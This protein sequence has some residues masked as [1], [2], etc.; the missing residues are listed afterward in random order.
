MCSFCGYFV[1]CVFAG[2]M[3]W[4]VA[5]V[6]SFSTPAYVAGRLLVAWLGARFSCRILP[7]LIPPDPTAPVGPLGADLR[8]A[9]CVDTGNLLS[10][11]AS[12]LPSPPAQVSCGKR[13]ARRDD[14]RRICGACRHT[15][16]RGHAPPL[17]AAACDTP[18]LQA[19]RRTI[20]SVAAAMAAPRSTRTAS[21]FREASVR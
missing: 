3:V 17:R 20:V 16:F 5:N 11:V 8:V 4:C 2:A 13:E 14:A 7:Y 9:P 15:L 1:A 21:A 6:R 19:A 18:R 12:F 10:N